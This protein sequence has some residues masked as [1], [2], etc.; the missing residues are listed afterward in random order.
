MVQCAN[1]KRSFLPES[2]EKHK[3]NCK[4]I[5]GDKGDKKYEPNNKNNIYE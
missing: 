3:K 1:C 4:M 2:Y 5:N